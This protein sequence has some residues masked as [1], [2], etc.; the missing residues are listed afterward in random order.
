VEPLDNPIWHALTGPLAALGRTTPH[1][2][3]KAGRFLPDVGPFGALADEPDDEAWAAMAG[4]LAPGETALVLRSGLVAEPPCTSQVLGSGLQLVGDDIV[5]AAAADALELGPSDVADVLELIERARPGPYGPR[6]IE[7]G[8]YV[9]VRRKGRLVAMAG[10]RLR[11]DGYVE[12]SAVCT[13][14][15]H[16][17]QGLA[18]SLVADVV[19]HIR[20]GGAR[21]VLH[22]LATNDVA[23][24]LYRSMGFRDRTE[25]EAIGVT[26]AV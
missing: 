5:G 9:G 26:R 1:G 20:A 2:S 16:Q 14:P 7:T 8:R 15:D 10:E 18:R 6:T 22:V 3:P 13:D 23:L 19:H 17:G 12:I 24:G 25:M 21:P 4:L 11:F